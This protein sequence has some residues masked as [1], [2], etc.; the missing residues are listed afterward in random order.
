MTPLAALASELA[1]DLKGRVE[2][3]LV[4]APLTTYR[5]GGRAAIFV[6]PADESDLEVLA[7][8]LAKHGDVPTLPLGRG[9]NLL[10]SDQGFPGV[11]IRIAS[12]FATLDGAEGKVTTGAGAS[13][14]QLSN[15][16][17]RRGLSGV[18]FAIAIPGSVGGG[19]RMNAGAHGG[20]VA[21]VLRKVRLVDLAEG[22]V[23]TVDAAAL[24]LSY[25]RSELQDHQIVVGAE[26]EL[27]GDDPAA[28][29]Q[30]VERFRNHRADTQP[31]A[32]QNA[33]S[34]FK[35]PPGDHA[36]RLV[37]AAGL[38]GFR[39]GAAAVAELHANFFIA[40]PGATA[41]DVFDLI[42]AVRTRVHDSCGIWLEPE[43]RFV[44]SFEA[45]E[46][47]DG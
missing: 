13:L 19:V 1:A 41:R 36:G 12:A 26:L 6:E 45:T 32:V 28:V 33:G 7:R 18:E 8:S 23:D 35:N 11:L 14:P 40:A 5:L 15:W 39:V 44:G 46:S 9:S 31:P 25:R 42:Q 24:G 38:K 34:V 16:A 10:F 37:E 43:V 21:N 30:R 17:A 29:K 20:E 47:S 2:T 27:N 22:E 3:D 4:V